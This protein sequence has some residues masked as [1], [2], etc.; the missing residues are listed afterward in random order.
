M[1][2]YRPQEVRGGI[3]FENVLFSYRK[4][5]KSAAAKAQSQQPNLP[6]LQNEKE[7]SV[8]EPSAEGTNVLNGIS[9]TVEPGQVS[10]VN[11]NHFYPG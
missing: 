5:K 2:P 11:N 1:G 6:Q 10:L 8:K 7:T 4:P 3:I 9:F